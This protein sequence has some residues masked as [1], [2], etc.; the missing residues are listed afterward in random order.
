MRPS[1]KGALFNYCK[2]CAWIR[3]HICWCWWS[4]RRGVH[5]VEDWRTV[6]QITWLMS[7][8]S[9]CILRVGQRTGFVKEKQVRFIRY[10]VWGHLPI[11]TIFGHLWYDEMVYKVQ[12]SLLL[13]NMKKRSQCDKGNATWFL[14]ME[15]CQLSLGM[16]IETLYSV[17]FFLI[18][19]FIHKYPPSVCFK[20]LLFFSMCGE[21]FINA[22]CMSNLNKW[23]MKQGQQQVDVSRLAHQTSWYE[24]YLICSPHPSFH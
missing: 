15:V 10:T 3:S 5:R 18:N 4:N 19:V 13:L 2:C 12:N 11:N 6:S 20:K 14:H 9:S 8:S 7:K 1:W 17:F 22:D 16:W 21:D 24:Q 23:W